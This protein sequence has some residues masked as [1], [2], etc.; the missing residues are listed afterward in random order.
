M[1]PLGCT[2]Q[3]GPHLATG[4]DTWF[5]QELMEA[6]SYQAAEAFGIDAIVLPALPFETPS[7]RC[8]LHSSALRGALGR[9]QRI[10]RT[11]V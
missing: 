8:R 1:V 2:E 5:A 4:F 3:Q 10:T 6:A 11:V 9:A 7:L